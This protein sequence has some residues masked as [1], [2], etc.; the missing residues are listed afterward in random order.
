MADNAPDGLGPSVTAHLTAALPGIL[1][2]LNRR[3]S[4]A[5]ITAASG[6]FRDLEVD[7]I[8]FGAVEIGNLSLQN[9]TVQIR[10]GSAFLQ[11]VRMVVELAF[12]V[13]VY[14]NFWFGHGHAGTNLQ[15]LSFPLNFGDVTVTSLSEIDLSIP[16]V[17]V[18]NVQA[19]IPSLSNVDLNGGSFSGFTMSNVAVPTDG[20]QIS[21]LGLGAVSVQSLQ[22]PRSGAEKAAVAQFQPTTPFELPSVELGHISVPAAAAPDVRSGPIHAIGHAEPRATG[23]G[24]GPIGIRLSVTPV[25]YISIGAMRFHDVHLAAQVGKTIAQNITVPIDIRGINLK[26]I[27]I[28]ELT[29]SGVAF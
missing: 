14:W 1:A 18:R 8:V 24:V 6:K 10:T 13:E 26:Q 16:D 23:A 11:S 5:Q 29:V 12:H 15:S 28:G 3:L 27:E 25:A 19:S 4:I 21:G 17:S 9:T 2:A 7:K 20:F 22:V